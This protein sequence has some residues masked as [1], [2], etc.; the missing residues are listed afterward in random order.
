M[1]REAR[2]ELVERYRDGYRAVEAALA[3]IGEADLDRQPA[4]GEWSP[5]QVVHHL[6]D[7]E[8]TG[9]IRLRR[10]LA[11][12]RPEITGYDQDTF[13]GRLFYDRPLEASLAL[14]AAVR[15]STAELLDQMSEAEWAREGTHNESGRY[16]VEDWLRIYAAHCHDHAEQMLRAAEA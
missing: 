10:L 6:A 15:A 5:R 7:S 2:Q 13:A 12:D 14:V 16:A 11:E 4:P 1:E 3:R 8:M 9:S